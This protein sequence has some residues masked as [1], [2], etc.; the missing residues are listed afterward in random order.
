MARTGAH[1]DFYT[2]AV[3]RHLENLDVPVFNS[4][5]SIETVKDKLYSLQIL[6][7]SGL[8][9]PKTILM[10]HP[11][12]IK[13]AIKTL[14]MPVII[15]LI[16]GFFF[17]LHLFLHFFFPFFFFWILLF[18]FCTVFLQ[19]VTKIDR[20]LKILKYKQKQLQQKKTTKKIGMQGQG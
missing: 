10:K 6:A 19:N 15:K 16:S 3:Y 2:L 9:V 1:T 17:F 4:S 12:N 18:N 8:P 7:Q 20:H 13:H 5:Q 11:V 14:G